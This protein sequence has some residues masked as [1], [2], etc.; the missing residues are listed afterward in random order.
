MQFFHLPK[1]SWGSV[2]L[3]LS[4]NHDLGGGKRTDMRFPMSFLLNALDEIC[5]R[6]VASDRFKMISY[7]GKS[8]YT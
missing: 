7:D 5:Q 3:A 2:G 8:Y 4:V 1:N 6:L